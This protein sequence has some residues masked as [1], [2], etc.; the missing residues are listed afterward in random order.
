MHQSLDDANVLIR[1]VNAARLIE[2]YAGEERKKRWIDLLIRPEAE[3]LDQTFQRIHN[4]ACWQRSAMAQA[5]VYTND[6]KLWNRAID[7]PFGIRKQI[8][9][10]V[11]GE[12]LWFEQSLLYNNYVVSALLPLFTLASLEGRADELAHEMLV[13]ENMMLAPVMLRFPDGRLPNPADA[14]GGVQRAPNTSVLASAYR[15]F[16]TAIGLAAAAGLRNWDTL[17]DPPETAP[18]NRPLPEVSAQHLATSRMAILRKG[19]WQVFVHYGQ[20]HA[21]HAQ[22]EALNFEAYYGGTD[23]THDPGT[24]GYGSPLHAGFYR[25][26]AAHNVP[27]IERQGQERWQPGELVSFAPDRLVVTQPAYQRG[28]QVSRDLRIDGAK[29]VDTVKIMTGGAEPK[30]LGLVLHLQG[31]IV[32]PLNSEAVDSPLPY[33]ENTK[34]M[35][36]IDSM[37]VPVRFGSLTLNVTIATEGPFT[38][39][40]GRSPDMPPGKRHSIYVETTGSSAEFRTTIGPG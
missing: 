35:D 16:P 34:R 4:I 25:T 20:L 7:G 22:S 39:T 5:A 32:A 38:V 3:L 30:R 23:V 21:S 6:P 13:I 11:T 29:L 24:V 9:H 19:N 31:E 2:D 40:F 1:L 27:L 10:G 36:S 18:A 26:G 37:T 8:E 12:Y 14:T 28:A 15:V 17:V 33:W